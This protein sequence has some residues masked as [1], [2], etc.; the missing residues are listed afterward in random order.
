MA[1]TIADVGRALQKYG[2]KIGE[3]PEFGGVSGVH[4]KGSHHYTPGGG[5]V[6]ITDWRKDVAPAFA[7]GKP[8]SWK[9]RTGELAWRAKQLG[10]FNEVLGPGDPGHDTHVHLALSGKKDFTPQQLEW[11]ATGRYKDPQ[12]KLT[13]V[14][15]GSMPAAQQKPQAQPQQLPQTGNTY[16]IYEGYEA[17]RRQR[18][19]GEA[20]ISS[21]L[22]P[23]E[24]SIP[25]FDYMGA[26]AN[27]I[28]LNA[29]INEYG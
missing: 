17:P 22:K 2:L 4:A 21:L 24:T 5:A 15:P 26:L 16:I 10:M 19:A 9:Q 18:M 29:P 11:L 28:G 25:Q 12:G 14:M 1:F 3:H 13:D 6:D 8:I 27:A 7:G 23:S 20:I